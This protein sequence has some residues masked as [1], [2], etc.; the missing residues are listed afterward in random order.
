MRRE[1][2]FPLYYSSNVLFHT[3]TSFSLKKY[4]IEKKT[5][6]CR[7]SNNSI[8]SLIIDLKQYKVAKSIRLQFVHI[9]SGF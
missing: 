6:N 5:K 8:K 7:K 3:T 9:R 4:K 1:Y 2:L